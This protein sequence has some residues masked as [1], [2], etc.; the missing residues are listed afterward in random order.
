M[1][2]ALKKASPAIVAD[3]LGSPGYQGP[4]QPVEGL[5]A[6]S[7]KAGNGKPPP[8]SMCRYSLGGWPQ[9][10]GHITQRHVLVFL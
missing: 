7:F 10:T 8:H 6:S 3:L 5:T 1:A 4:W 9:K 2:N